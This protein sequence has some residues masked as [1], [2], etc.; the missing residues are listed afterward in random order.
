MCSPFTAN[1]CGEASIHSSRRKES[2]DT[3]DR[4]VGSL[5]EFDLKGESEFAVN[6][7]SAISYLGNLGLISPL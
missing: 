2:V 6:S 4:E 5:R 7:S 1:G 3:D